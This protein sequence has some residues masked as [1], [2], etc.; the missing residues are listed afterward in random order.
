M[1]KLIYLFVLTS[2]ISS[3]ASVSPYAVKA[4]FDNDQKYINSLLTKIDTLYKQNDEIY[5]ELNN[6]K[7][8]HENELLQLTGTTPRGT[9][10]RVQIGVLRNPKMN[11]E[12]TQFFTKLGD[13]YKLH[14]GY[15]RSMI[16]AKLAEKD[17]RKLG[18]RK[19]DI[20]PMKDGEI[21]SFDQAKNELEIKSNI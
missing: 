18:I 19:I 13:D 5:V 14:I 6:I 4:G 10:Y 2:F 1:K 3:C 17:L 9:Y 15:F 7:K 21:I 11:L 20:I 8:E 12:E 16:Q